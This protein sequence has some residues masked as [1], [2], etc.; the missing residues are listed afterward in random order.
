MNKLYMLLVCL[1]S[2][3]VLSAQVSFTNH[4][5]SLGIISGSS[6]K[7]CAVDMNGDYLDDVVRVVNTK[8]YIDYQQGDGSFEHV[9]H[10]V[11]TQNLP[12]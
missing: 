12:T 1:L 5:D 3:G 7:D 6:I 8:I 10:P 4:G 2:Y 11:N 9:V